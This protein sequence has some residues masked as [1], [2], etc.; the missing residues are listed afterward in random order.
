VA[1]YRPAPPGDECA[2]LY[3][4]VAAL[5]LAEFLYDAMPVRDLNLWLERVA[6]NQ[7]ISAVVHAVDAGRGDLVVAAMR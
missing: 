4:L 6:D 5:E 1:R 2:A 7:A 3:G